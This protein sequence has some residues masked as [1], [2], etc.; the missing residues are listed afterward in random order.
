V[1]FKFL[2]RLIFDH[3]ILTLLYFKIN[4]YKKISSDVFKISDKWDVIFDLT[5]RPLLFF[6]EEMKLLS[7]FH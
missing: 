3:I 6:S 7:L 4:D 5:H 1:A 2:I